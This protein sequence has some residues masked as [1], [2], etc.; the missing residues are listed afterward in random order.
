MCKVKIV[1][2]LL[3]ISEVRF[4]QNYRY[5]ASILLSGKIFLFS[6]PG[7]LRTHVSFIC[8]TVKDIETDCKCCQCP[9]GSARIVRGQDKSNNQQQLQATIII[10]HISFTVLF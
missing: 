1:T 10:G 6:P 4:T 8:S 7:P 5:A 2:N 3:L 9:E